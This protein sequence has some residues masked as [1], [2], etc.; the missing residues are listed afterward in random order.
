M[1]RRS[2]VRRYVIDFITMKE[3][4]EKYERLLATIMCTEIADSQLLLIKHGEEYWARTIDKFHS[5]CE[6]LIQQYEG[7]IVE[8]L[9]GGVMLTFEGSSNAKETLQE[10]GLRI[11]GPSEA[12]KAE[13]EAK[14]KAEAEA[15]VKAEAEAKLAGGV[16][17]L[18]TFQELY[19]ERIGNVPAR[20][21]ND[22]NWL[23]QKLDALDQ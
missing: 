23:R 8:K 10:I 5:L 15:K 21:K 11:F 17:G 6:Q 12:E 20:Y 16:T 7:T 22:I 1:I 4:K 18:E 19:K 14:V 3:D 9:S 2:V 13:A